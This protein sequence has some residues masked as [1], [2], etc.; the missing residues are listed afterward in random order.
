MKYGI[1][2]EAQDHLM[3][4]FGVTEGVH[5]GSSGGGLGLGGGRRVLFQGW[6]G[7]VLVE[8]ELPEEDVDSDKYENE[9]NREDEGQ[10]KEDKVWALY[11]DVRDDGLRSGE[12][13][14]AVPGRR[15]MLE[16]ELTR[17]ERKRT[18]RMAVEERVDRL[19]RRRELDENNAKEKGKGLEEEDGVSGGSLDEDRE[20]GAKAKR[21]APNDDESDD[22]RAQPLDHGTEAGEQNTSHDT[23]GE[24]ILSHVKVEEEIDDEMT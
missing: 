21:E 7:W 14:G 1:R 19:Q 3:G 4:P 6:E 13:I 24:K 8:E 11:F 23:I 5:A 10:P 22:D 16:V 20:E 9:S 18:R 17:R 2:A 15:N 12:R